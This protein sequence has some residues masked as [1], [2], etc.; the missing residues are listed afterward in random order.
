M[1]V[2]V[3]KPLL[4]KTESPTVGE[5]Q[6]SMRA[7]FVEGVSADDMR[8]IAKGLVERAKKGDRNATDLLFRYVLGD[9][10]VTV[11][12]AVMM[13]APT[14]ARP[15]TTDKLQIMAMRAEKGLPLS[16]SGDAGFGG[17]NPD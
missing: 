2:P 9:P 16:T 4:M 11:Q 17:E 15:G 10:K 1:A 5:W 7:A 13:T 3:K 8:Q 12:N 14:G 6:A